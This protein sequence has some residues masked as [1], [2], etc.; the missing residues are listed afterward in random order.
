M[1]THME[2]IKVL[3]EDKIDAQRQRDDAQAEWRNA[4]EMFNKVRTTL[5]PEERAKRER[6]VKELAAW[7]YTRLEF[8]HKRRVQL[9]E[10]LEEMLTR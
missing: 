7:Y 1:E 3:K 2:L 10:A 8:F 4:R 9:L 6:E 5:E